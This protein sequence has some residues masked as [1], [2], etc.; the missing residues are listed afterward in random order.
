VAEWGYTYDEKGEWPIAVDGKNARGATVR[1]A[2]MRHELRAGSD[3]VDVACSDPGGVPYEEPGT[4][5]AGYRLLLDAEGLPRERRFRN[6]HGGEA[7]D[8]TGAVGTRFARR[9]GGY[10]DAVPIRR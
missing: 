6:K 1:T 2:T 8:A 5:I 9:P 3:L 10:V 4:L 7:A